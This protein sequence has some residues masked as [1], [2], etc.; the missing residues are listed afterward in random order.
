MG[1]L[2]FRS[3]KR[4]K[5]KNLK[6]YKGS[7]YK[8]MALDVQSNLNIL[9]WENNIMNSHQPITQENLT[10]HIYTDAASYG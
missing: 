10:A 8:T 3:L 2:Y 4:V 7:I 1:R 5:V 6:A 9:W